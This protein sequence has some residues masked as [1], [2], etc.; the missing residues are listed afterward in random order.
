MEYEIAEKEDL[1]DILRLYKQ[2]DPEEDV[3]NYEF[4]NIIWNIIE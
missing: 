1:S 2:L 4:A 3:I